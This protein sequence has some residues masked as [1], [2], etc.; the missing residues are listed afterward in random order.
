MSQK[1][2]LFDNIT[3][4]DGDAGGDLVVPPREESRRRTIINPSASAVPPPQRQRS[5]FGGSLADLFGLA[6]FQLLEP[7]LE[8][9]RAKSCAV[10]LLGSS[11]P[12][13]GLKFTT[14]IV[15]CCCSRTT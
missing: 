15:G 8:L 3:G 6:G 2:Q 7:Q 12:A 1:R 14:R 10:T 5:V 11:G 4:N 9:L 13:N